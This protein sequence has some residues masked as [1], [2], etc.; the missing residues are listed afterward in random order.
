MQAKSMV[1]SNV[2]VSPGYFRI[3]LAVP[4]ALSG[5]RPGQ[6]V[7]VKVRD[8]IDPLLRRPFGI[9]DLGTLESEYPDGS[10]QTCLEMLYRGGSDDEERHQRHR[11]RDGVRGA[12]LWRRGLGREEGAG[13]PPRHDERVRLLHLPR[14]VLHHLDV[15]R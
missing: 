1:L 13:W 9:F 3:R 2:E 5:G 6:F 4:R 7:M 15:L 11:R 14:H 12:A 8:A 10:P